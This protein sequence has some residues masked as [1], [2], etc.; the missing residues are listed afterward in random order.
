MFY[1]AQHL[2]HTLGALVNR[3]LDKVTED[4][5]ETL[6][7]LQHIHSIEQST[8]YLFEACLVSM[9]VDNKNQKMILR[10]LLNKV[11]L[12]CHWELRDTMQK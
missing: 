7:S 1:I 4:M 8:L 3:T 11:I 10:R 2:V 6:S 5:D 9:Y 12:S